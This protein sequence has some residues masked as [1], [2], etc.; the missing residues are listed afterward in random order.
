M[1]RRCLHIFLLLIPA[2]ALQAED[3]VDLSELPKHLL[4]ISDDLYYDYNKAIDK[5]DSIY[6]QLNEDQ[7]LE[8]KPYFFYFNAFKAYKNSD[9][10]HAL[11]YADSSLTYFLWHENDEWEARCVLVMAFT[12]E[13]LVLDNFAM[14]YYETASQLS[15]DKVVKGLSLLGLARSKERLKKN[16][17]GIVDKAIHLLESTE[18]IESHLLARRSYYSFNRKDT[19]L[20]S[21]L[22]KVEQ[23][24]LS[25]GNLM[26][27]ATTNKQVSYY[28]RANEDYN[29]AKEYAYRAIDQISA[30]R[31]SNSVF[32]SSLYLYSSNILLLQNQFDSAKVFIE[33]AIKINKRLDISQA[34]FYAY[35][36]LSEI[37]R[38]REDYKS[39]DQ[40]SQYAIQCQKDIN[41]IKRSGSALLAEVLI[42]REYIDG[43]LTKTK[44]YQYIRLGLFVVLSLVFFRALI[45]RFRRQVEAKDVEVIKLQEDNT[46]LQKNALEM[47]SIV[48]KLEKESSL[49]SASEDFEKRLMSDSELSST[50]PQDFCN[51][52]QKNISAFSFQHIKLSQA[53]VR[54]AVM[55]AMDIPSKSIV[56]LQCIEP[57]TLKTYRK[58]IRRKLKLEVGTDLNS[59]LKTLLY[60]LSKNI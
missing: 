6:D 21:E 2:Y 32:T 29:R 25:L 16:A 45:N 55:L 28:Y 22:L 44:V 42:N 49:L 19:N 39:A 48:K 26:Y 14:S 11:T 27:A 4:S 54:T 38:Y 58:R 15:K 36:R 9:Y 34:N 18:I 53:E 57:D 17:D 3:A 40:N 43:E 1:L 5:I 47:L 10:N 33:K 13:A 23:K 31:D 52:Y 35:Q 30:T 59:H 41:E 24:Y 46:V 56:K 51:A 50:L 12:A 60:D 7:Q 8:Y 37:F 20:V